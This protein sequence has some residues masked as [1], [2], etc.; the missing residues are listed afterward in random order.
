MH[1]VDEQDHLAF[2][3]GDL[4]QH[5]LEPLLEFAAI[6]RAG[7]QRA[8]VEREQLLVLKRFRHVAVDDAQGE[9]FDDRGLA[10]AGLADQ[11]GIVLGAAREHLNCAAN[12]LVASDDRI[13]L[14]FA[15]G[16][17]EIARIF[18][19]RVILIL[20]RGA[21]G[22]AALAQSLD[23]GVESLRGDAGLREDAGGVGSLL[24]G[25]RQ[26]QPL[27]R[28]I[29]VAGLLRYLLGVVEEPRGRGRHIELARAGALHLG[30]LGERGLRLGQ[31]L[32]RTSA[33]AVDKPGGQ[34]LAVVE[35][36]LQY[37]LGRELLMAFARRKRLRRLHEAA[38]PI[39]IFVDIH[40]FPWKRAEP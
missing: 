7:D 28:D 11:H 15:R 33:G 37:M 8:H 25:E 21:V 17:R 14:A 16:F 3:G 27:D 29:G 5:G 36:D 10:D 12:L 26:E 13:E 18:L 32:A 35:Q 38:N 9:A 40:M 39:G 22:R 19:Q 4:V 31:R 6:F 30:E 23:R 20:G 24:E 2:G 34:S 1:L